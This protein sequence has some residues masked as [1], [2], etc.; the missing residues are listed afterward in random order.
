MKCSSALLLT[1]IGTFSGLGSASDELL[2]AWHPISDLHK[3]GKPADAAE[4]WELVRAG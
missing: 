2:G 1:G 3:R 4:P